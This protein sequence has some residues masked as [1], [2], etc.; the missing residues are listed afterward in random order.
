MNA[1]LRRATAAVAAM[2]LGVLPGICSGQAPSPLTEDEV[3]TASGTHFPAILESLAE[4]RSVEGRMMEAEGAFDLVFSADGYSRASGFYDGTVVAGKAERRLRKLG[5]SVYSG[6]RL[7]DGDFPIYEDEYY[8]N[9][10]GELTVGVLFSLLRDREIDRERFGIVDAD[11]A[12]R[13]ADQDLLLTRIGV[14]RRALVAYWA[15]VTEGRKLAV[16][17]D[18]VRIAEDR[19]SGL[20]QQ[21]R[22]GA[23]AE[24]FLVENRQNLTRRRTL[25]TAAARDFR[26]SA[27]ALSFFLRGADGAPVLPAEERLPPAPPLAETDI[28]SALPP[29]DP[30]RALV[31]RPELMKLRATIQRVRNRVALAENDLKPR[32]DLDVGLDHDFGGIAEGGPSRDGTDTKIG[33]KFSLP[34]ERRRARG[35]LMSA[36]AELAALRQEQRRRED[37]IEIEVRSILINLD[38]ATDLLA[39][40]QE[41]VSQAERMR[42]AEQRRFESGASD[43]F[44]VNLREETAANARIEFHEARFER[45]RALANYYAATVDTERLE[46]AD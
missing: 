40:A 24:I 38:G 10:G 34:L 46:I 36:E 15:W 9:S 31:M 8:T 18:L 39:L 28:E 11:L 35:R 20:E 30:G 19:E 13:E 26:R 32:L 21:V 3:L 43:F 44:L 1:T 16:Y 12:L 33:L 5:A 17:D 29:A 27:N 42:D 22:R 4:R 7:S 41:Q 6:Y 25:A 14:Q 37:E 2:T 23:R 45:E